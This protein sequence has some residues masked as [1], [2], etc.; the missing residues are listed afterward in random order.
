MRG[1]MMLRSSLLFCDLGSV[2]VGVQAGD[3]EKPQFWTGVLKKR[4]R[5]TPFFLSHTRSRLLGLTP[6]L[7]VGVRRADTLLFCI[8]SL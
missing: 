8:S 6:L 1:L 4:I 3:E 7:R 2:A 5:H